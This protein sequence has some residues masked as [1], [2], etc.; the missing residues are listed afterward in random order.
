MW[1]NSVLTLTKRPLGT[2]MST[3]DILTREVRITDVDISRSHGGIFTMSRSW[4]I[5]DSEANFFIM[6]PEKLSKQPLAF[7]SAVTFGFSKLETNITRLKKL[8][9][10]LI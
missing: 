7:Y 1:Q 9:T 6:I 3:A 2:V 5:A 10:N 4:I 8:H